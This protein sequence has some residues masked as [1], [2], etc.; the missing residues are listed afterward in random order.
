MSHNE[1]AELDLRLLAAGGRI[2]LEPGQAITYYTRADAAGLW[3]QYLGYGGG[4]VR[5]LMLHRR[6]PKLRQMVPLA[7]PGA[8]ALALLAPIAPILGVPLLAY[9]LLTLGAG[10]F[11]GRRAGGGCALLSGVPAMIAHFAWGLGFLRGLFRPLP[12]P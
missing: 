3:R 8:A 10:L 1:D 9:I 2:W 11:V 6:R 7:V 12:R 4:R 5:T